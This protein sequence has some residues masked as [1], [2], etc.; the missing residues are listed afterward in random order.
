MTVTMATENAAANGAPAFCE[1]VGTV[2]TN[3]EDAGANQDGF[4]IDLPESASWNGKFLFLGGGGFDGNPHAIHAASPQQLAMG[5][6]TAS[7]DS[8]TMAR[9]PSPRPVFRTGQP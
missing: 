3:G 7:T 6:A 5:Y 1:V 4:L 8:P 2:K 9:S